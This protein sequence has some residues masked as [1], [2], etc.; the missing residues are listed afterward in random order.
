MLMVQ[1]PLAQEVEHVA[2]GV[3]LW[4]VY[5]RTVRADLFS[6]GLETAAGTYL[7]DPIP[8]AAPALDGL[9]ARQRIAGI[10]VTNANHVRASGAFAR[11][12]GVPI[13]THAEIPGGDFPNATTVQDGQAFA[14]GLTGVAI[15]GGPAG[16]MAVHYDK[17]AGTFVLGDALINFEPHGLG[18]LPAKYCQDPKLMRRSLRKLLGFSFERILFAHGTPIL[19]GARA[20][21][22]QLLND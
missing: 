10:F 17:D 1:M 4:Q 20:R 3:F 15:E 21:L 13:L 9:R 8:L 5:D 22:E 16:E 7:F 18:L 2:S 19:S 6:T 11:M 14:E 12:S